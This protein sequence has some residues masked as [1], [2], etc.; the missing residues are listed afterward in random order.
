MC[1]PGS[2][3]SIRTATRNK[4]YGILRREDYGRSPGKAE[5]SFGG[6]SAEIAHCF[7]RDDLFFSGALVVAEKFSKRASPI[8]DVGIFGIGRN[9][10]AFTGAGGMPIA[11]RDGSI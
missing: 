6:V 11:E 10:A 1:C 2:W 3:I 4:A 5:F 7:R 8:D 9:V